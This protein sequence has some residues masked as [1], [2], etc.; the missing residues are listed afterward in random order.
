MALNLNGVTITWLGHAT[1]R[2]ETPGGKTILI[3]PW[4]MGNPMCPESEKNLKKLDVMLITHGHGDHIGD[5]VEIAKKHSPKVVGIPEM[6]AWLEKKGVKNTAM[7]NKGGTQVVADVKVT[8]VHADHSCGIQDG[9]QLI[10]GG[11]ACG[12]VVEFDNGVKVYHAGDTNVFGDMK[13]IHDLYNPEIAMLPI[14]DH[15]TM[16]PREAAYACNLLKPRIVIPMHF[17]TFPM[18]TG[19]PNQLQ[20]LVRDVEVLEMKPGQTVGEPQRQIA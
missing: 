16:S 17:G 13:I 9:D 3:D 11:E 20:N 15:F 5:A 1:F 2:I 8:M 6:T 14:G 4:V 12:Y 18:L 7:M 19:R 10:Y